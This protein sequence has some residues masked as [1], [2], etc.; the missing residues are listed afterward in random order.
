MKR[1]LDEVA[2]SA[3]ER[4]RGPKNES[5]C[6]DCGATVRGYFDENGRLHLEHVKH[7]S[8]TSAAKEPL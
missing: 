7:S 4:L 3:D 5:E 1:A 2:A 6:P 8:N